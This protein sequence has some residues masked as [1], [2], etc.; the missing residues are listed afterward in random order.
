MSIE[1]FERCRMECVLRPRNR[2]EHVDVGQDDHSS[3]SARR[4][5]SMVIGR[6]PGRGANVGTRPDRAEPSLAASSPRRDRS[7]ITLPI[8]NP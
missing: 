4:T 2:D 6:A 5:L 1:P 8:D 3:S 7:E